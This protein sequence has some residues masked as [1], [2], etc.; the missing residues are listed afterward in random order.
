[1]KNLSILVI[2]PIKHINGLVN[3]MKT[4]G[5]TVLLDDPTEKEVFKIISN[6]EIIFTNP[7]KSKV[8]IGKKLIDKSNKLKIIVTASTG[9]IHIDT[10]YARK[11][12]IK[13]I[14]LTKEHKILKT[15][16]STAEHALALTMVGLRNIY[17]G[18]NSV[19]N[20]QW[21]YE[22]FIGRQVNKLTIGVVGYGRLGLMYANYFLAL[23]A[24]VI[25]FD[26]YV[27][28]KNN[29][30]LQVKNI[31]SLIEESDVISF[32][33]HASKKNINFF[34]NK[35]FKNLKKNVLIINTSR[36]EI[37]N[38]KNL[39]IH[40]KKN[41]KTRYYTDVLSDEYVNKKSNDLIKYSK[42]SDQILITPHIGGM[43][44]EAQEIA[45]NHAVKLLIKFLKH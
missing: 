7:N 40:L 20:Y 28:I 19:K 13:V 44:T 17:S 16:T 21:N 11:K 34:D 29:K 35:Q 8:Y 5:N 32:H 23:N 43:T 2:T 42:V 39:L 26:P 33:I 22:N 45:Y 10:D 6:F 14:S 41:H 25:V 30:I 36:G 3:K 18:F 9:L 27:K 38:E 31:N 4:I 12:K 24:R 37:I 15:V 1:M